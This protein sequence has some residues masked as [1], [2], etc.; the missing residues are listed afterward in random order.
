MVDPFL[1]IWDNA[2]TL[3]FMEGLVD[4]AEKSDKCHIIVLMGTLSFVRTK[5]ES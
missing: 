3:E 1:N 2:R 4:L 5:G